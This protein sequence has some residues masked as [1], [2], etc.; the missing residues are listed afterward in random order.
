MSDKDKHKVKT[1]PIINQKPENM[2]DTGIKIGT[3]ENQ[4]EIIENIKKIE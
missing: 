3:H 2:F 4:K 1:Q